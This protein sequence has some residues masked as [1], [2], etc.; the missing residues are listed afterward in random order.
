MRCNTNGKEEYMEL[1]KKKSFFGRMSEKISDAVK[2]KATIDDALLDELEEILITSDIG[3][4]TT[5]KVI[6]RL[7]YDIKS[8]GLYTPEKVKD[9]L[10]AILEDLV[11]KGARN[12]LC[13]D[14]PLVITMIGINGG[15]KTTTIGKLV[16]HFISVYFILSS[17]IREQNRAPRGCRYIP[18]RRRRAVGNLGRK[19]LCRRR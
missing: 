4:E 2:G 11:D 10:R 13:G 8:K 7:R 3:M 15:G 17:E 9:G 12:V 19:K 16:L 5:L 18:C 1:T 6:D 14:V